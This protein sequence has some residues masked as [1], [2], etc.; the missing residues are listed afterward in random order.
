MIKPY[1]KKVTVED[2]L[3]YL[4]EDESTHTPVPMLNALAEALCSSNVIEARKLAKGLQI[5]ASLLSATVKFELGVTLVDLL[6]Q[7]RFRQVSEY[8]AA[9]PDEMLESVA[10][11][12]G[13]SSY[14]TLWRFMQR[15]GGV[16]PNGKKSHAG[17]ERW[18]VWREELKRRRGL[19]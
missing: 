7:F 10:Q 12:F 17:P 16:T 8:V 4:P 14:N 3:N 11:R 19:I 18:L 6:H 9:H 5:D 13:Y 2:I 1:E 15:V